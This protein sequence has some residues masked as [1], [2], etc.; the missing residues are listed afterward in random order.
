MPGLRT[1]KSSV[2]DLH[3]LLDAVGDEPP[4][5]LLGASFGGLI[6]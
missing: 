4:Y 1:A 3:S 5:V 2:T 6:S